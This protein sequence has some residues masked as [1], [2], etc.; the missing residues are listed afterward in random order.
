MGTA[1]HI[2]PEKWKD[3]TIKMDVKCDVYS[4]GIM[5]WELFAD[6]KPFKDCPPGTAC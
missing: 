5:L 4:F 1:T 3:Y 6:E 2:A